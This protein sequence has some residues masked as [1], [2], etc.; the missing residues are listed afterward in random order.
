ME[1]M[2]APKS[3]K[4]RASMAVL[5][6]AG[7]FMTK[8]TDHSFEDRDRVR[9]LRRARRYIRANQGALA[10]LLNT[11]AHISALDPARRIWADK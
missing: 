2:T 5:N 6:V 3:H 1:Q 7:A 9:A 11:Y 4:F 8:K 10:R